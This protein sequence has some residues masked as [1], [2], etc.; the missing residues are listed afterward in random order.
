MEGTSGGLQADLQLK[1]GSA[2]R[3]GWS[4]LYPLDKYNIIF[5]YYY[6]RCIINN[7][8]FYFC[9]CFQPKGIK[10][11]KILT[12]QQVFPRTAITILQTAG[13]R[14]RASTDPPEAVLSIDRTGFEIQ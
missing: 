10:A 12:D 4:E 14:H 8:M 5:S 1:A 11:L 9:R 6:I 2:M 13:E 7:T 3:P